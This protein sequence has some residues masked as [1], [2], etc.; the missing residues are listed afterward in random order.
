MPILCI[1]VL[2]GMTDRGALEE[3]LA[4]LDELEEEKFLARFH[5][6]VEK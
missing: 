6:Q 1:E 2:I 3:T 5:Q 4:Q